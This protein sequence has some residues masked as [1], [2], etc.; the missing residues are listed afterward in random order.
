MPEPL[1]L[2]A[3]LN[4]VDDQH[5]SIA[6]ARAAEQLA[7]A[8]EQQARA[9]DDARLALNLEARRVEPNTHSASQDRD[10]SRASLTLS[11]TLYDF[12]RTRQRVEASRQLVTARVQSSTLAR[13][14]LRRAIMRDYF[15][16]L[17]ADLEAA[18]ANEAMAIAFVRLD[19]LRDQHTL[20]MVSDIELLKQED[21]YQSILL[22]RTRAEAQQRQ[23]RNQLALTLDHPGQLSANVLAPELPGLT[24]VLPDYAQLVDEARQ[25]NAE[26]AG[27][28]AEMAALQAR[29]QTARAERNPNLY[30]QLEAWDYQQEFGS[31]YPL[32]AM[33]GVDVPLYQGNR[34]NAAIA[35]QE[36]DLQALRARY[37]ARD[38]AL[39][40]ELL[41][42][43]N[44]IKTLTL[45]L[46]QA[47]IRNDYRERYLDR[48]R[49]LYE[50]EVVTDLGDAMTEQTAARQFAD[51][52]RFELALARET[53]VA[54]T[55][56]PAYSALT[57]PAQKPDTP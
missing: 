26:L 37:R 27:L 25:G 7:R 20:K 54:L 40:Q 36:A 41:G 52:T 14:Q 38:Y 56:N 16:V 11:K 23:T 15:A 34:V 3:A 49:A 18:R 28:Q 2:E 31:R 30:L 50:L 43:W 32:V 53:L 4:A 13:Q 51:Q 8:G 10:D 29:K 39:Q 45:Q 57:P 1:T 19:K 42:T 55:G 17:L 5:P 33:L 24:T 35:E 21:Q 47:R 12:G 46:E 48:S 9:Q 22:E 44:Q 6:T